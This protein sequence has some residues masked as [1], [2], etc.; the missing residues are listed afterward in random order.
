MLSWLIL[1]KNCDNILKFSKLCAESDGAN[2]PLLI[3]LPMVV[4]PNLEVLATS[5]ASVCVHVRVCIRLYVCMCCLESRHRRVYT[6]RQRYTKTVHFWAW[7]DC[8]EVERL[9]EMRISVSSFGGGG[10]GQRSSIFRIYRN[11]NRTKENNKDRVHA[12]RKG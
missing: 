6:W 12:L 3:R 2:S 8:N 10:G 11:R 7:R 1:M 9:W 4:S 5:L